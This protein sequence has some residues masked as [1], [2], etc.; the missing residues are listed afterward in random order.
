MARTVYVDVEGSDLHQHAEQLAA[1]FG[2]LAEGWSSLGAK[3]VNQLHERTPDMQPDDLT[4]W[5]LGITLPLR[6]FGASQVEELQPFLRSLARATGR[7]F[8]VG[9]CE[10]SGITEDLVF[11]GANSGEQERRNLL[12]HVAGL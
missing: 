7:E 12:V 2:A 5:S 11:I 1:A 10:E 6:E 3:V 4:D 9:I 8:I